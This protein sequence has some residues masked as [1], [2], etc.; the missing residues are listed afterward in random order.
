[1]ELQQTLE[2]TGSSIVC[3]LR[4][5]GKLTL[6]LALLKR[7]GCQ[8]PCVIT[9]FEKASVQRRLD[10]FKQLALTFAGCQ[11][12]ETLYV[13]PEW[14]ELKR[15]L[16][17]SYLIDDLQH[18]IASLPGDAIILHR[19][20]E[21][22]EVQDRVHVELFFSVLSSAASEAGKK[23]F[24]TLQ[25]DEAFQLYQEQVEHYLDL[26][27]QIESVPGANH[28]RAI[29][30]LYASLPVE[31]A[32]FVLQRDASDTF[33]IVAA[34]AAVES[35]QEP[36]SA[37]QGTPAATKS[38]LLVSDDDRLEHCLEYILTDTE[39]TLQRLTTTGAELTAALMARPGLI[40]C[41]SQD[42]AWR[43]LV[44]VARDHKLK[45][46][47]I[48][49]EPHLRKLDRLQAAQAG[50]FDLLERDFYLEDLVLCLERAL[51]TQVYDFS[52]NGLAETDRCFECSEEVYAHLQHFLDN[53]V[54]FS[55]FSFRAPGVTS[56]EQAEVLAGRP[57]DMLCY[58]AE[59]QT[60][61]FFAPNLL[62][63]HAG[64]ITAKVQA[65]DPQAELLTVQEAHEFSAGVAVKC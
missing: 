4:Q 49:H 15:G 48:S 46:V 64:L 29:S 65:L 10:Q 45:V 56:V 53:R 32:H 57:Y 2:N 12:C 8:N 31:H 41:H 51:K 21:F 24:I 20:D 26:E 19:L 61:R 43:E 55:V 59:T 40:L 50:F 58:Q 13:K 52:F 1:M 36:V 63:H 34:K 11:S 30:V 62:A 60:L 3:G 42:E 6:V 47:R 16:G 14:R 37:E 23:L 38:V 5:S 18:A 44:S 28:Q 22:F 9:P 39:V 54:Y 7:F 25:Q 33:S 27:L 17:F 35:V